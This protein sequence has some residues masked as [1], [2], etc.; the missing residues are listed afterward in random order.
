M[1]INVFALLLLVSATVSSAQVGRRAPL[2][3]TRLAPP[4]IE[5][6][7]VFPARVQLSNKR[8][9]RQLVVSGKVGG[10]MVDLTGLTAF[11]TSDP[12]VAR[13]VRGAVVPVSNGN[14]TITANCGGKAIKVP[15]T[16]SNCTA[17]DPINFKFET[18]PILTKQGCANGSCHGSPHGKGGF[19]LSLFGYDPN[20]DR[21]SLTRDGFNRRVNV[22]EPAESLLL[23]KPQLQV[24]HVGGKRLLKTDTALPI[25]RSWI[26]EGANVAISKA[27]CT[28]IDVYP[29]TARI[30]KAPYLQQQISVLAHYSDGSSRDVT[31]IST[32]ESSHPSVATVDAN[33]RVTGSNRGQAG[34]SVRYLHHLES[35]YFTVIEDVPGFAW[36]Q[37]TENNYVDKLVNDKL[38]QLKYLPSDTCND[39]TFLRRASLDLTGLLPLA[40]RARRYLNDKSKDKRSKLIDELLDTEE[41]A[42]FWSLK[43]AD[44]MRVTPTKLTAGRAELF[45]KW[46]VE[47]TRSN[48]PFDEFARA[49]LTSAGDTHSVAAANYF[50]AIPTP[51]ERTEMTA[52]V[53]MGSRLEC[54]K[55]HNHPFENWTMKDY[56]S[57]S[58]VFVRTNASKV[59]L[60]SLAT[61]GEVTHPTSHET[62][63]PWGTDPLAPKDN[64]TDR[65]IAYASWLTRRGN[66][67]FAR[68]EVNRIWAELFGRGIVDPVDDFR[69][70]NPPANVPLLDALAKDFE[71]SGYD[72]KRMIRLICNSASY[73][74]STQTNLFNQ[75]EE[76]LFSHQRLRLLSAEQ[77]K[78]A[79]GYTTHA[80]ESASGQSEKSADLQ[81]QLK[82]RL[83]ELRKAGLAGGLEKSDADYRRLSQQLAAVENR[84]E[85]ATQRP[86]P[87]KTTFTAAFGQPARESACTC[88]RRSAPTLM[89]AL[90]LLN[91]ETVH[92]MALMSAG[93]F[94]SLTDDRVVEELYLSALSRFPT[95]REQ[96]TA[97]TYLKRDANRAKA[98]ADLAWTLVNTREFLFQH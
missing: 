88:E 20:I 62:L 85:Y 30:L 55:C 6:W 53:F 81:K 63:T 60:V 18:L 75:N 47:S 65:R 9:S 77:L 31:A 84:M 14:A 41:Y 57:L 54:A 35:L 49:I 48:M 11:E 67:Y 56:Y 78:D 51:E 45:S 26:E 83:E 89:Q 39:E 37:T 64:Q 43:Q 3:A 66:P 80:L 24:P 50:L 27:D 87:E 12:K 71:E 79:I 95:T 58:A 29:N 22:M 13:I 73:Q 92:K 4:T 42:R 97:T 82:A 40:D 36:R 34:V 8:G 16:V 23:K 90:E 86:Y 70:S 1:R 59:G 7:D 19:S 21:I 28:K 10:Q 32:F 44:I 2:P 68:V 72:R 25:L 98:L 93:Q 91:G 15:L 69:S 38:K 76:A 61:S 46:I 74:R 96:L 52:Q 33:G 5:Q 17:S 94:A